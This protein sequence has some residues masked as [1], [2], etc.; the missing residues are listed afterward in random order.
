[1]DG[2]DIVVVERTIAKSD[3][4]MRETG[5]AATRELRQSRKRPRETRPLP[6]NCVLISECQLRVTVNSPF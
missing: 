2:A 1:M 3:G 6:G 4:R 5:E